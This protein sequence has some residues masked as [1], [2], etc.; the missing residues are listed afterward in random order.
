[1][2]LT[3]LFLWF[4][5]IGH[6][7]SE[8]SEVSCLFYYPYYYISSNIATLLGLFRSLRG[9]VETTWNPA[10]IETEATRNG[11]S[12]LNWVMNTLLGLSIWVFLMHLGMVANISLL[13]EK[14][15]FL[16]CVVVISYVYLGYPVI[17]YGLSKLCLRRGQQK[18]RVPYVTL[19]ICAYNEEDIIEEKIINSLNLDYPEGRLKIVIASDGSSDKTNHIV[20]KYVNERLSL[21]AHPLRRGKI[22]V[23]N[24]IVPELECDIVV[25]SDANTMYA[26]DAIR[27]LVRNF[28]DRSVGCVS[29]N[30]MIK[31][32]KSSLAQAE[33]VYW[34]YERWLQEKESDFG[35]V[36]GADGA[37]YAIRRELFTAPSANIIVDDFVISMNVALRGYRVVYAK[38]AIGFED[39]GISL[40]NEFLRQSRVIAGA[41]QALKQKEGV[42]LMRQRKLFFCFLSHKVLRWMM[43]V[44]HI[45]LLLANIRLF[46]TFGTG[47]YAISLIAQA[48]F[49]VL[50]LFGFLFKDRCKSPVLSLPC[51]YCL[52]NG[53]ALYGIY[54]GL[55]NKQSVKWQK[56]RRKYDVAVNQM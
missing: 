51:Y 23:I 22:G 28:A 15:I 30:V 9:R 46:L 25:F 18:D 26:P 21:I 3:I 34:R 36:I 12:Y 5:Y 32:N 52:E 31:N 16:I 35:S 2:M 24:G 56:F 54:K 8:K 48:G 43:P 27:K 10:R 7:L 38:E 20:S 13:T 47:I 6:V 37:M 53:A 29:G 45:M 11:K 14:T 42:P 17:I 19:L 33:G 55:F 50:A 39:N 41:V 49:Y 1:M 44:Y 40:R 4:A